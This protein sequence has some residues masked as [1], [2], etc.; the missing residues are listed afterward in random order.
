MIQEA[1]TLGR[2]AFLV[3]EMLAITSLSTVKGAKEILDNPHHMLAI[4]LPFMWGWFEAFAEIQGEWPTSPDQR[5]TVHIIR[6]CIDHHEMDFNQACAEG[7]YL[8]QMWNEEDP[9]F[10]A[11]RQR[12]R[13]A[14]KEPRREILAQAIMQISDFRSETT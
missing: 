7:N 4:E 8:D 2:R 9:L 14:F 10:E 5:A 1:S 6:Y 11:F 12:G 3:Q 13:K